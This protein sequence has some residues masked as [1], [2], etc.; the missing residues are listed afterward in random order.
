MIYND[1]LDIHKKRGMFN[2][3]I[4]LIRMVSVVVAGVILTTSLI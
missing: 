3:L 1:I 4:K 2:I